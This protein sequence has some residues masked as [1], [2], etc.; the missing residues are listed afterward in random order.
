[1]LLEGYGAPAKTIQRYQKGKLVMA[2]PGYLDLRSDFDFAEGSRET[3]LQRWTDNLA[4]SAV[5]MRY[6]CEVT[7]IKGQKGDFVV[8]LAGGGEIQAEFVVLAIGLEG[9]PRNLGVKGEDLDGVEYHLDDPEAFRDETIIVVGAGDS[10]IE[11][12][13]ALALQNDVYVVN[14][15]DEFSRAKDANLAA[16]LAASSDP[17]NRLKVLYKTQTKE[18]RPGTERRLSVVLET[19]AGPL[20][21]AADRIIGRLGA[22]PPRAFVEAS[23]VQ[24]PSNKPEAIPQLSRQYESNV[25]GLYI[26]GS[27]AGYPLI[28]QAMNQGYDVVEFI[29]GNPIRPADHPLLEY[30]FRGLPF[31]R[32]VDELMDLFQRRI[33]MFRQLNALTFRELMIES[34]VIASYAAGPTLED[35]A[36]RNA[37]AARGTRIAP[38]DTARDARG[39]RRRMRSIA[40]GISARRSSRSLPAR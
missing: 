23:G 14:R 13:L 21:I 36:G 39:G 29:H 9:N 26:I 30:Q 5:N 16:I 3:I 31:E 2:E 28:K 4:R 32:D 6:D 8:S 22:I 25:E 12:A 34:N 27:L 19:D 38:A 20:E 37:H 11:N 33:P 7:S 24:F 17:G 18:I 40:R 15:R 10:A 35:A 1:M